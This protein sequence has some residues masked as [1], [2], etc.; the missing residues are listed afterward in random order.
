MEILLS[1]AGL[2]WESVS[3][4]GDAIGAGDRMALAGEGQ[5]WRCQTDKEPFF[6]VIRL[7]LPPHHHPPHPVFK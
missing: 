4:L 7:F 2:G 3:G 1:L 5:E 6:F